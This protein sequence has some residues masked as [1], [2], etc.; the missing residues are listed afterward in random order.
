MIP[1]ADFLYFGVLLYVVVP[2]ILLGAFGRAGRGWLL[3]ATAAMLAVQYG[4]VRELAPGIA[5]REIWIVAAYA[6]F[7]WA[8]AAAFVATRA[9]AN[10]RAVFYAALLLALLPLIVAKYVPLFAPSLHVGF[11]GLSYVTLRSLDV[12]FCVQD[13]VIT[14]LAPAQYVAYLLFFPTIS[15][16][17]ID[18]YR[19]FAR[20]WSYRR[21]RSE[22]IAD[23]DGAV[24]RIFTGFLYKFIIAALIKQYWLDPVAA[25]AG[26]ASTVSYMYAY[27]L[28]LFFDFAGYSAFAIGVSY[29]FGIH[30]PENF[31]R[32]F[33]AR[34]IRDFWNRWHITLSW[35]LRDHVYMRFVMAAMK[36]RWFGDRHV[37]SA[38]GL[39]LAF[40]LM[41]LWHGPA[42]H[43][44]LYGLYHGTLLAAH[45]TFGRWNKHAKL[46]GDGPW[47]RAAGMLGTFH[48]VCFGFL[49]F[50][51]R[52]T[53]GGSDSARA[54][55]ASTAVEGE[56]EKASCEEVV[57]WAWDA[58]APDAAL[59]LDIIVDAVRLDTV[60]AD[61]LRQD[62]ADTG[63]GN[64][65]HAFVFVPPATLRD[66]QTH[67]IAV[68]MAG[69]GIR[70]GGAKD[71]VCG[72][73]V[74]SMDGRGGDHDR[75]DCDWIG[76]WAWD[77][78]QPDLPIAVD[79]YAG[80]VLLD[81]VE[82][83]RFGQSLADAGLGNGRH[84]FLLATPPNLKDGLPHPIFVRVA[85]S[86]I[87]LRNTPRL[88]ACAPS[89][90]SWP[91]VPPTEE[92]P[93][94]SPAP[95]THAYRD[96]GDGTITAAATGLM[97]EKKIRMDGARDAADLHDA[98]NC[99]P[100]SGTCSAG[101][102]QCRID[103]DC[104]ANGPCRAED[105]Q[106]SDGLTIFKWIAALNAARFAGHDDWRL[107]N[108]EELYSIVNP[109]EE[110]DPAANAAF[111]G[112]SCGGE[113]ADLRDPACSCTQNAVYWA[114]PKRTDSPDESWMMYFYCNGHLFLDLKSNKFYV[115]AVRGDSDDR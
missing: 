7:Q 78:T 106:S 38:L 82:A 90:A 37:A 83:N 43:Y 96:N 14:A 84:Q 40:T 53:D 59:R 46:W 68:A 32:P 27:T 114:A 77:A 79:I 92:Q 25:Q 13:R 39:F 72:M 31:D 16:G 10:R 98:D 21:T 11:L 6:A 9:R 52:L 44:L 97:W 55:A 95:G 23:L 28:H 110:K 115:R 60:T 29:L 105:C 50:S 42:L 19:R 51:G 71:I 88:V 61:L 30:T 112:A 94:P 102:T 58:H 17:P 113:C 48:C 35:W 47:W 74:V 2:T 70:L 56:L 63:K 3:L 76:G 34:N 86:N 26:L 85:G 24:H 81:T 20:D 80:D 64:G 100:W 65:A 89:A 54:V 67:S 1:Y 69:T 111:N 33:L 93:R 108:S 75:A 4:G 49:L 66:G 8:I 45:E 107:P 36:R 18:R 41:G 87:T 99:Y 15:S 109:I 57:G 5:L 73:N 103:A 22:L 101:G 91:A 12:I 104:G 62:L